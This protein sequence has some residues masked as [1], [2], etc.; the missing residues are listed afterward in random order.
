MTTI[1]LCDDNEILLNRY[2]NQIAELAAKHSLEYCITTFSS[3]EQLLFDLNDNINKA[4]I[5]YLDIL[6]GQLNGLDVARQLRENGYSGEIIFL[7]SSE[8]FVFDSF[9]ANPLYYILKDSSNEQS[10]LE[11][12]FLRAMNLTSKKATE[13]F[14]CTNRTETKQ[15]PLHLISYFEIQSRVIT[16]HYDNGKCFEF[17]SSM[18]S[19]L[20][21]LDARIFVRCHRSFVINL[22]YIDTIEAKDVILTDGEKIPMGITFM[23][24]LKLAFSKSLCEIF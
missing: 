4:D 8:E 20:D 5:I 7:T 17:Y 23:K 10:K 16:L 14:V 19:L 15:I 18:E 24:D 12:S 22:K 13:V 6:M 11:E 21:E 1:Y 3:G 9:D 2:R